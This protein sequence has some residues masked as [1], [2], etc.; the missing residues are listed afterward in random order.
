V[1]QKKRHVFERVER[2]L[3]PA[4]G[5]L[6]ALGFELGCKYSIQLLDVSEDAVEN[7]KLNRPA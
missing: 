4:R 3:A 7:L 2:I 1:I 5:W 6:G